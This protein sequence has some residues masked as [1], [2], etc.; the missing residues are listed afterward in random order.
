MNENKKNA[1]TPL[2]PFKVRIPVTPDPAVVVA[3]ICID[4]PEVSE[5]PIM[6][7][8]LSDNPEQNWD[9]NPEDVATA[10]FEAVCDIGDD[11]MSDEDDN[12]NEL[13]TIPE[14]TFFT[15]DTDTDRICFQ[16]EYLI[17]SS[18]VS[19]DIVDVDISIKPNVTCALV[20]TN[21]AYLEEIGIATDYIPTNTDV[22]EALGFN[23]IQARQMIPV[24]KMVE[25]RLPFVFE[26]TGFSADGEMDSPE[27][28]IMQNGKV[29]SDEAAVEALERFFDI[30]GMYSSAL[31]EIDGTLDEVYQHGIISQAAYENAKNK[32]HFRC[33][34]LEWA[35]R[36]DLAV[37]YLKACKLVCEE[38]YSV[39]SEKYK[40]DAGILLVQTRFSFGIDPENELVLCGDVGSLD[41]SVC[42][43]MMLFE[44]NGTLEPIEK[45]P[46]EDWWKNSRIPE[47][48]DV[49][50]KIGDIY[51]YIAENLCGEYEFETYL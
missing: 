12:D 23:P 45:A 41:C 47:D 40:T 7:W 14:V 9:I 29:I 4:T 33:L 27:I 2:N 8:V 28:V 19:T 3:S 16:V 10:I 31:D 35:T 36:Y 21:K 37:E 48:E 11:F 17:P 25:E 44:K 13:V 6:L 43:S 24:K 39:L 34:E 22:L 50:E 38:A 49:I 1:S 26:V 5:L 32:C 15:D 51:Y 30:N 20:Q 46:I 42:A 18:I